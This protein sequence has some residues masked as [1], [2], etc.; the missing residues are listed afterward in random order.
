MSDTN[1]KKPEHR[2]H[3]HALAACSLLLCFAPYDA[4]ACPPATPEDFATYPSIPEAVQPEDLMV[5]A[6]NCDGTRPHE[7][8]CGAHLVYRPAM[9]NPERQNRQNQLFLFLPGLQS[10]P[11]KYTLVLS[12]AA[13]TGYRT[14]GLSYDNTRGVEDECEGNCGCYGPARRE[15]IL[16]DDLSS[17]VEVKSGDAIVNRLYRLLVDLDTNYPDEGWRLFLDGDDLDGIQYT[18]IN[19]DAIV[20]SGHSQGGTNAMMIS[21]MAALDGI[22]ALSGGND[23]CTSGGRTYAQWHDFPN[24]AGERRSFNY[25]QVH[26]TSFSVPASLLAMGFGSIPADFSVLDL[27]WP[28]VFKVAT[29]DQVPPR[30]C[31]EH[32]SMAK[33]DCMP[34]TLHGGVP[35]ETAED[36]YLFRFYSNWMCE[37]GN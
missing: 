25:N 36:A 8:P 19:W 2:C 1:G 26:N 21:K 30:G 7:S 3:T 20:I 18:D 28:T 24:L 5:D 11:E 14:I 17:N 32:G 4:G 34:T 12:M 23:Q 22:L 10:E 9:D 15:V 13:Y 37:V 16:G 35:A 27:V 33:D 6:T 29:T 31:S